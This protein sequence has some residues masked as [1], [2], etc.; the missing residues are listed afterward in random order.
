MES[1]WLSGEAP[2]RGNR[3]VWG[4]TSRG[5]SEFFLCP[6][7]MGRRKLTITLASAKLTISL[8]LFRDISLFWC[9]QSSGWMPLIIWYKVIDVL[10]S[11]VFA[12][13]SKHPIIAKQH[14]IDGRSRTKC[15]VFEIRKERLT[16]WHV[17]Y[18]FWGQLKYEYETDDLK[19][20]LHL[21]LFD[22]ESKPNG[23]MWLIWIH[24][25]VF[26]QLLVESIS[27][28]V[29]QIVFISGEK[30]KAKGKKNAFKK[31]S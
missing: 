3:Q 8:I 14:R 20:Y 24:I 22:R 2:E 27:S 10:W 29:W 11:S 25:N 30:L 1:L 19:N 16:Y 28:V 6:T 31:P 26:R 15:N 23:F 12:W 9:T 4:S 18:E 7:L 21:E 17:E 13:S 5:G